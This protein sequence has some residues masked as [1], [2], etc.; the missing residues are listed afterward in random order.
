MQSLHTLSVVVLVAVALGGESQAVEDAPEGLRGRIVLIG[1]N[2]ANEPQAHSI[3][4]IAPDGSDVRTL[5]SVGECSI[6]T[7]RLSPDGSELAYSSEGKIWLLHLPGQA[8]MLT[9]KKGGRITAWSPD[10]KKLSVVRL[11][12]ETDN[13]SYVVDTAT[14]QQT[15]LPLSTDHV[16]EDWHPEKQIRTVVYMNPGKWIFRNNGMDQY[17]LR[18]LF[19][20]TTDAKMVPLT[21]D[22][23]F[24]NIW[25]R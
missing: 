9:D 19:S 6:S 1:A 2:K 22:A 23:S 5:H 8:R 17:P 21:K 13:E 10:G 18:Q 16:A 4:T 20:L 14:G 24:D 15:R 25:S 12:S 7:G 11:N 3:Q